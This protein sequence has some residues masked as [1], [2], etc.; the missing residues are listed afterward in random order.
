MDFHDLILRTS[1][2]NQFLDLLKRNELNP[3]DF[4]R[5]QAKFKG[6]F[7]HPALLHFPEDQLMPIVK[8]TTMDYWFQ[9]VQREATFYIIR[10]PGKQSMT[11]TAEAPSSDI[12]MSHFCD[13]AKAVKEEIETT[14]LWAAIKESPSLAQI[15]SLQL[16]DEP[17]SPEEQDKVL[18]AIQDI[19][20][21]LIEHHA[22]DEQLKSFMHGQF[23]R[24]ADHLSKLISQHV[25]CQTGVTVLL[26]IAL[27]YGLTRDETRQLF[28]FAITKL[29]SVLPGLPTF[30][31][32]KL[33]P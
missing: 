11:D 15:V 33:L 28:L 23:Q 12:L 18:H 26:Q 3:A 5:T 9:F 19:K 4:Q 32:P 25:W 13:W 6:T 24:L 30:V 10:R 22:P 31:P 27:A 20:L 1:Q 29:S 2:W 8:H 21:Y 17:F 14:D 16:S 7:R